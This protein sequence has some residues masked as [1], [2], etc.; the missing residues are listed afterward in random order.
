MIEFRRRNSGQLPDPGRLR[1]ARRARRRGARA[2]GRA[3][4]RARHARARTGVRRGRLSWLSARSW[5]KRSLGVSSVGMSRAH[6]I[7]NLIGVPLP[8]VG[9]VARDRA[10]VGPRDRSARARA[11]GRLLRDHRLGVTLGYHR[12]F[13]HRAFESSRAFRAAIAVLGS[14]AVQ[15]SVI[16]WVADHRKH[17]AFTDQD[18]DPHSPHLSGPG[19]LG[20]RQGPVACPR[21][22]A[23]RDA[24]APRNA[25]ASRRTSSRIACVRARRQAVLGVGDARLRDAVRARLDRRRRAR[26]GAHGA[27]LGRIRPRVPAPPR[28]LVD[29]L[30]LPLLRPPALRR[31]GR[32]AQRVLA[33]AAVDGRGLAPQPSRLPHLGLPRPAPVGAD[34]RPDRAW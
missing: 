16:T 1:V 23:V 2:G 18:G 15:G 13:T 28:H 29:Q 12:M 4:A 19:F 22:L 7:V 5:R 17:H 34:R 3:R 14:M 32:V 10:A 11:D 33:R 27:A 26:H 9:L 31:R 20:A 6:K 21:R 30:G 24:S 8:L 25:S